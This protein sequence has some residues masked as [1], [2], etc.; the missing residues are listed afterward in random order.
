[1]HAFDTDRKDSAPPL[2][3][4]HLQSPEKRLRLVAMTS[5]AWTLVH[6]LS[7]PLTSAMN[8]TRVGALDLRRRGEG[9]EDLLG[10]I[11]DAGKEVVRASEIIGRMRSFLVTGRV[12]AR[13]ENLRRMIVNAT[14][15]MAS[16]DRLDVEIVTTIGSGASCVAADRVQIEQALSVIL[17]NACEAVAGCAVRRISIDASRVGDEVVVLIQNSGPGLSRDE[18]E[19]VFEPFFTTK[20]EGLGLG[21]PI[22]RTIVEAHR[23]RVWVESPTSGRVVFGLSLP[24]AP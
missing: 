14:P 5:M 24:S 17:R 22:C 16:D 2:R 8:Y 6:E 7:Q 21:M 18:A 20:P 19:R 12:A 1:M 15:A 13:R 10:L 9:F 4:C 3:S 23:G 11:E